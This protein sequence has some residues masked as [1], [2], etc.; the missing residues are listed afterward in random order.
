MVIRE[1]C[2][3]PLNLLYLI[4]VIFCA[5]RT[6]DPSFT[7]AFCRSEESLF[8]FMHF[9]SVQQYSVLN[10]PLYWINKKQHTYPVT[11]PGFPQGG[12]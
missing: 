6:A 7:Y 10:I 4:T 9:V 11:D 3:L 2:P 5:K 8:L 1:F 12:A